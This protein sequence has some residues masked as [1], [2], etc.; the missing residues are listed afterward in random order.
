M[1]G[2]VLLF[3]LL[4]TFWSLLSGFDL[5][6]VIVGGLVSAVISIIIGYG[7]MRGKKV[8]YIKGFLFFM[9][10]IPYYIFQEILSVSDVVYRILSGRINPA[11]VEIEHH[12]THEW[13][14]TVLS[15]SI[16]M[17]PGTL[18]LEASPKKLYIHW[19]NAKGDK[20]R[21]AW[22]FERILKKIWH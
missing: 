5:E 19:L 15:N 13:G 22:R 3:M 20:N 7:F 11:I 18:T 12:H 1:K 14:I 10:Y 6:D 9:M 2:S 8:G 17:T 16:T 21:I 4:W